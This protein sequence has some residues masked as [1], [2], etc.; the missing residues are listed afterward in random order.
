M[1]N[2]ILVIEDESSVAEMLKDVLSSDGYEVLVEP[3]GEWGLRT[4]ESKSVDLLILDVLLPQLP[5][6]KLLPR[7]RMSEKNRD[8]PV[9]MMSG[10]YKSADHQKEL[11]RRYGIVDYLDKPIRLGRLRQAVQ[12]ALSQTSHFSR[13][14]TALTSADRPLRYLPDEPIY[15][16]ELSEHSFAWVLG[17]L[18]AL[19]ST[20][21]LMLRKA[22]VKKIV[23]LR[24]GVPVFVKSNLLHECLGR[25]MVDERMISSEQCEESLRLKQE[26]GLMQGET[27]VEMGCISSNNLEFALEQQMETKLYD[28]FSWLEGVFQ[29]RP[30]E[31]YQGPQVALSTGPT[32]LIHE[33]AAR[34][35]SE[36]RVFRELSA[37]LDEAVLPCGDP[38]FRYQALQ[39]DERTD[40]LLELIDGE[41]TL[42]EL[43]KLARFGQ[44]PAQLWFFALWVTGLLGFGEDE[45]ELLGDDEIVD[46]QEQ[47]V[48]PVPEAVESTVE[49][50]IP[51][52]VA[53]PR[54]SSILPRASAWNSEGK[55]PTE[56]SEQLRQKAR[57]RLAAQTEKLTN[58]RAKSKAPLLQ[59]RRG[60]RSDTGLPAPKPK[61][62]RTLDLEQTA[63]LEQSLT[64]L[65]NQL[66]KQNYYQRLGID[67][68]VA[69]EQI[70]VAFQ[71]SLQEYQPQK[72][73]PELSS[74]L[75]KRTAEQIYL[76]VQEAGH[77]LTIVEARQ[78]YDE[79]LG[80]RALP[81]STEF[82]AE[83]FF[84]RG[85]DFQQAQDFQQALQA[86]NEAVDLNPSEAAYVAH[87]GWCI[88]QAE[89][90]RIVEACQLLEKAVDLNPGL[91]QAQLYCGELLRK[92]GKDDEALRN[93]QQALHLDPNCE[94][95][96]NATR[97]LA[98]EEPKKA[99]LFARL[100]QR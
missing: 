7:L 21:V 33:G 100:T 17:Q 36:E 84:E 93:Y 60:R 40:R 5:G 43:L 23:Y 18:C 22:T 95:A 63:V 61:A 16:G 71:H 74:A 65:R 37:H 44:E 9:I 55:E 54:R 24:E 52:R 30:Q 56:L 2:T 12:K 97:D 1:K 48:L 59:K 39:L 70:E 14:T 6:F 77:C 35:M 69:S 8:L 72:K 28:L 29:F 25:L 41:R 83:Q 99:G 49:N 50:T 88:Y 11:Q 86:Y 57:E 92:R 27:L 94:E 58:E 20:G 96:A 4:L 75:A 89:P 15:K 79:S 67:T 85:L 90:E 45:I 10:V 47:E 64:E 51:P 19:R 98:P 26:S 91:L 3:D 82:T 81:C 80:L 53:E 78:E 87:Q 76:L 68:F 66:E 42:S 32:A 13:G 73:V 62:L 34:T 46:V 38:A 31:V